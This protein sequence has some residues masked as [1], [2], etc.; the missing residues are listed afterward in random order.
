MN[1]ADSYMGRISECLATF[2]VL[3][4]RVVPLDNV[5][6]HEKACMFIVYEFGG[7]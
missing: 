6:T 3:L 1:L 7:F 2:S 4:D 5:E